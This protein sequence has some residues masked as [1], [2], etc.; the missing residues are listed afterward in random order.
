MDKTK[1]SKIKKNPR[2]LIDDPRPFW[3]SPD[4]LMALTDGVF[5]ITMTLLVIELFPEHIWG[6]PH[7]GAIL[8]SYALGFY[9]LGVFWV[10]HHYIFHF[11]KRSN[12]ALVW[13]NIIFLAASSL[14]PFWTKV[15]EGG[16]EFDYG[17]TLYILFMI[18]ILITLLILWHYATD[19]RRLVKDDFQLA[20]ISPFKTTIT[21]GITLLAI[22]AAGVLIH[23]TLGY[24]LFV[25]GAF[26]LIVTVYGPHKVFK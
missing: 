11:I 7:A 5:A 3:M 1:E 18:F 20:L 9:S 2:N 16:V 23:P 14:T 13:L 25:V 4:R 17:T 26:F 10:L 15:I 22:T 8:Y 6:N 24:F 12:G 21:I 19:K